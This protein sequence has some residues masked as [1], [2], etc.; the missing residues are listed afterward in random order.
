MQWHVCRRKGLR[1][2]GRMNTGPGGRAGENEYG[3]EE[4]EWLVGVIRVGLTFLLCACA[5]AHLAVLIT[6]RIYSAPQR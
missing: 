3:Q 4:T 2:R 1:S 6:L 5:Y